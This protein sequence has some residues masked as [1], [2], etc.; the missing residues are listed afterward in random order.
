VIFVGD[1]SSRALKA[2][3]N[4]GDEAVQAFY[5]VEVAAE[6]LRGELRRGDLVLLKG[7]MADRLD[8]IAT[9]VMRPGEAGGRSPEPA[10]AG[11]GGRVQVVVGLGNPGAGLG[12]TPHNVGHRVVDLLA[13]S[14]GA[15]WTPQRDAMVARVDGGGPT[16]YLIKPAARMNV[17]GP[18]VRRIGLRLGFAAPDCILVH[19]DLDL[20]MGSV[21]ARARSSD[22]GHR[23]V[24]SVF[25]AFRTDEIRRVRVGVG[26]P[27]PGQPVEEFVLTPFAAE[28]RADL[29]EALAAA[30]DRALEV[31]GRPER[32]RGRANRG[33]AAAA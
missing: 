12:E 18:A 27:A 25:R 10:G 19:D 29:D 7:S 21:R 5:S 22:G 13:A 6:H 23:G 33:R 24:R 16:T 1:N 11:S 32:I 3:R 8:V 26:R 28:A 2:R 17:I 4:E 9:E 14:L 31:L 30:A 20:P 15:S